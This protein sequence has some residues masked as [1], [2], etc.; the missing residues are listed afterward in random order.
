MPVTRLEHFNLRASQPLLEQL[1]DFYTR[2]IGLREGTR[3]PFR[4]FGHWLYA[5]EHPVL[6]LAEGGPAHAPEAQD[7]GTTFAHVAFAC[8][9]QVAVEQQLLAAGVA[10]R[11]T[12]VPLLGTP[13]I[14]LRDPAGNGVELQF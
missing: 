10:F 2:V 8:T 14:F 13:Q 11:V 1:R 12:A 9:D 3:P 4:V 7:P 5:G 6:H